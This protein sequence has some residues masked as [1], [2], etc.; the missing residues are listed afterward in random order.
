MITG[1]V[2]REREKELGLLWSSVWERLLGGRRRS[3]VAMTHSGPTSLR[4]RDPSGSVKWV[5]SWKN[6]C[7]GRHL[8]EGSCFCVETENDVTIV[9]K[10]ICLPAS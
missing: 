10:A 6:L 1:Y 7:A 2:G 4:L 3:N 9:F 8:K 5:F